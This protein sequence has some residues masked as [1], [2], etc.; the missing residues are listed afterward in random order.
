VHSARNYS[1]VHYDIIRNALR[2]DN[3]STC[4]KYITQY[5]LQKKPTRRK[6]YDILKSVIASKRYHVLTYMLSLKKFSSVINDYDSEHMTVL[7]HACSLFGDPYDIIDLLISRGAS[8]QFVDKQGRSALYYAIEQ[9]N[10]QC[11][12]KMISS[13]ILTYVKDPYPLSRYINHAF[14]S[15]N[16]DIII[17]VINGSPEEKLR[18]MTSSYHR[19]MLQEAVTTA[20][21]Q[22]FDALLKK[23]IRES[24]HFASLRDNILSSI[25]SYKQKFIFS[26]STNSVYDMHM[27]ASRMVACFLSAHERNISFYTHRNIYPLHDAVERKCHEHIILLLIAHGADVIGY[28][29]YRETPFNY[30]RDINYAQAW[31]MLSASNTYDERVRNCGVNH[32]DVIISYIVGIKDPLTQVSLLTRLY[33]TGNMDMLSAIMR[34]SAYMRY[35]V[36]QHPMYY[37]HL[38]AYEQNMS[39]YIK[40]NNKRQDVFSDITIVCGS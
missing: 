4:K 22:V 15:D 27:N 17:A 3:D 7:M 35:I 31:N 8:V 25:L 39:K 19:R 24:S 33:Y 18:I 13:G 34:K 40:H 30:A 38:H 32:V 36:A 26:H 10:A 12:Q 21:W 9:K 16:I 11:V 37:R 28:D 2:A 5:M 6:A 23:G 14:E 29:R 20:S 1:T